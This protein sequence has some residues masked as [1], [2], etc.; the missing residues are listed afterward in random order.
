M[1]R[2]HYPFV[3][4]A[5]LQG[6][7]ERLEGSCYQVSRGKEF[8]WFTVV[9]G[10]IPKQGP[11]QPLKRPPDGLY[12]HCLFHLAIERTVTYFER[13]AC[14]VKQASIASQ[15]AAFIACNDAMEMPRSNREFLH[16]P[17][18]P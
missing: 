3:V 2:F 7:L 15:K 4:T 18:R 6:S 13:S 14:S 1:F 16:M 17:L 5:G 8:F 12:S 10:W 11:V 9:C